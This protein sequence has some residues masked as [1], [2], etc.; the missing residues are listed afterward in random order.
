[1]ADQVDLKS[2][3]TL[4]VSIAPFDPANNLR[5]ALL[6]EIRA[7][8]MTIDIK[9]LLK[10]KM[11]LDMEIADVPPEAI[12]IIKDVVLELLTSDEVEK[13]VWECAAKCTIDGRK[14]AKGTLTE[15][16]SF[17]AKEHRGDYLLVAWEV[18]KANVGPFFGSLDL[19]SWIA[20]ALQ[21][22]SPKS[23]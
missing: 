13:C 12:N 10:S 18:I 9:R 11:S 21:S 6:A 14:V 17:D 19:R 5:K 22:S 15:P 1:M 23:E 8:N 4:I 7:V 3:R 16:G 2:G 20:S